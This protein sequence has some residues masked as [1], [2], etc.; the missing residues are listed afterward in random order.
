MVFDSIIFS[1]GIKRILRGI[2]LSI[3]RNSIVGLFGVN[4][5]GKSTLLKIGAGFLQQDEGNIFVEKK[6]FTNNLSIDRYNNIGYLSQDSFLPKDLMVKDLAN[7]F[8]LSIVNLEKEPILNKVK[9]QKIISLS[10]GEL[11]YLEIIL[12][13]SLDRQYYLMDEPF[14][15]IE[16]LIIEKISKL[17]LE[18]KEKG[19][20][21]LITDHYHRYVTKIIDECYLMRDGYLIKVEN[22]EGFESGLLKFGYLVN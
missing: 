17:I 5:S 10:E 6:V 19:K 7:R 13:F 11:R 18:Q 3:P 8:D 15:G 14:T 2:Y 12:L 4:G 9:N 16:P 1:Y 22:E 21:I 20:G